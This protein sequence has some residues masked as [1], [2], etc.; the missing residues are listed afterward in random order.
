M[1]NWNSKN[2]IFKIYCI[3]FS[4]VSLI[5]PLLFLFR[6]EFSMLDSERFIWNALSSLKIKGCFNFLT[7]FFT[8]VTTGLFLAFSV[9]FL[10]YFI[11]SFGFN[12]SGYFYFFYFLYFFFLAF[13]SFD[14]KWLVT[15]SLGL[16]KGDFMYRYLG[17]SFVFV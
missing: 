11:F 12:T 6:S 13:N 17:W 7:Y 4:F 3:F 15:S 8:V 5:F 16:F 14:I 1:V 10:D 2:Q 9:Y